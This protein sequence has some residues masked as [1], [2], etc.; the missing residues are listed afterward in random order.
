MCLE[1]IFQPLELELAPNLM[2]NNFLALFR[3]LFIK[4]LSRDNGGLN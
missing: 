4:P 1:T 2:M 3:I